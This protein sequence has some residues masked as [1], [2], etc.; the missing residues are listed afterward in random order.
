MQRV[1]VFVAVWGALAA[2][3][4]LR[5]PAQY[6]TIQAAVDA[7]ADGDTVLVAPGEYVI[8]APIDFNR[9]YDPLDP[10]AAPF[11]NL[12][13]AGEGS[14]GGT[15]VR[16]A[17]TPDDPAH[18]CVLC[19][20]NG[21]S[22]LSAVRN[23]TL[24]GGRGS[25][26]GGYG[27]TAGG[28]VLCVGSS[29]TLSDLTVTANGEGGIALLRGSSVRVERCAIVANTYGGIY[30]WG[31]SSAELV[32][33]RIEGNESGSE[34]G[35]VNCDGS[36]LTL[37]RCSIRANRTSHDNSG[38]G[39]AC[40][41][42]SCA[43][44]ECVVAGNKGDG[45]GGVYLYDTT[46]RLENC[47]VIGNRSGQAGGGMQSVSESSV[48]LVNCTFAANVALHSAGAV[49]CYPEA[50]AT[51]LNCVFWNNTPSVVE[52]AL[53]ACLTDV[54]PL[55]VREGTFD[56]GLL[57]PVFDPGDYRLQPDSPC[58]NAGVREGA[59]AIDLGGNRRVCGFGVDIGAYELCNVPFR[60]GDVNADGTVDI[61]DAIRQLLCLFGDPCVEHWCPDAS[62]A[63][64][65]GRSNIADAITILSYLFARGAPPPPPFLDC[66]LD[67]TP[68]D[69]GC[70]YR[71]P[72]GC[73]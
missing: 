71:K 21:E 54:D 27:Y 1:A 11:K 9:N 2:G 13:L 39:V 25:T 40:Y 62:D 43:M 42:S 67:P 57:D 32:D 46:A 36:S 19:F 64:D 48:E 34:G 68:D 72:T 30:C 50:A 45:G 22:E 29:P 8:T 49:S 41:H 5:V 47:L 14:A 44:R 51:A 56:F 52:A 28:G 31:G 66:G 23:L 10:G 35:A 20:R 12:T 33:C 16:M 3:A 53:T 17:E 7:A 6:A 73:N 60:R 15:V 63:N 65:D 69:I 26:A 4:E 61:A 37:V 70:E 58:V 18:A 38:G 59:P 24:A 55:F